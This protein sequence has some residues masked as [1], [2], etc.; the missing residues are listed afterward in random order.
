MEQTPVQRTD[1]KHS[2]AVHGAPRQLTPDLHLLVQVV[3]E[4]QRVSE[5]QSVWLH[6][7]PLPCSRGGGGGGGGCGRD[8]VGLDAITLLVF[9]G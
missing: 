8:R 2:S 3:V 7:M 6:W 9:V 5:S 4:D 1:S